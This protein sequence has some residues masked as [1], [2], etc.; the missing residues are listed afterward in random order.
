MG[1]GN[2]YRNK[3][4]EQVREDETQEQSGG[5]SFPSQK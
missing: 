4:F 5:A 3:A 1:R 2:N